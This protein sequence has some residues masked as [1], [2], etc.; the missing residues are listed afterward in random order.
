[1]GIFDKRDKKRKPDEF[2]SPVERIDL[3]ASPVP[4]E[5]RTEPM[6]NQAVPET[7]AAKP[8][9]APRARPEPEPDPY[10]TSYGIDRAIQLMRSLPS[11]NVELV[12]QV[13]KQTLEST[14]VHIP[15]IIGDAKR[16]QDD[17]QGR[18]RVLRD[19]IADYEKEIE[20]RREEIS[21]LDADYKETSLVRERLELA[22]NLGKKKTEVPKSEAGKNS[23]GAVSTR[24]TATNSRASTA[25]PATTPQ[26]Q[27]KSARISKTN[28]AAKK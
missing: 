27:G 20:T 26:A 10:A 15:E 1:M 2:D 8:K 18:I 19:E 16:K 23:T 6:P 25:T 5:P 13:V 22:E 21:R 3:N 24:K 28:I 4:V 12:V 14:N 17:I 9:S 11:D 7:M